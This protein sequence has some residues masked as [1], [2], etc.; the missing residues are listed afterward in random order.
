MFDRLHETLD[1]IL[2]QSTTAGVPHY[3]VC[4]Q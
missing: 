4:W 2:T 3:P 1:P